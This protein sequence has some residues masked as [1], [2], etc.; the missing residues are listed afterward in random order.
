MTTAILELRK[1]PR[2][3]DIR[4]ERTLSAGAQAIADR[5]AY[6]RRL[7]AERALGVRFVGPD[8]HRPAA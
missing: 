5:A 1:N 8:L 4:D 3:G 6:I 2:H 7:R